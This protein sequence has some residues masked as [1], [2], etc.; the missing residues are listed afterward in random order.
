M[1]GFEYFQKELEE[2]LKDYEVHLG[3][4]LT[5][6]TVNK[7][8]MVLYYCTE[9]LCSGLGVSGFENITISMIS[10][11]LYYDFESHSQEGMT[12]KAVFNIVKRFFEFIYQCYGVGNENLLHKMAHHKV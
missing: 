6:G 10:S 8:M 3:K 5:S 11:K 9:Y 7:H 4:T 12:R 1:E 2:Y